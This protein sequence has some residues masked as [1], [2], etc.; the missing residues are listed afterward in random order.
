[1]SG[2]FWLALHAVDFSP[3]S[4]F[5]VDDVKIIDPGSSS[6]TGEYEIISTAGE[7]T[8]S[9]IIRIAGQNVYILSWQI[10]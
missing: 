3:G 4:A 10:G 2:E 1:M 6:S 7:N 9:T 5:Y 8:I